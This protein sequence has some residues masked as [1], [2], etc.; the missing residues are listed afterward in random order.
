MS[1]C[2]GVQVM[3]I[4]VISGDA[5]FSEI[6]VRGLEAEFGT[7]HVVTGGSM[8][9][10][11]VNTYFYE[12]VILNSP[13][14]GGMHEREIVQRIRRKNS[15]VPILL[16]STANAGIG[17]GSD[18]HLVQP[19]TASVLRAEAKALLRRGRTAIGDTVQIA[20]LEI[21]R[22]RHEVRRSGRRVELTLK[23]YSLLEYLATRP[24]NPVSRQMIVEQ[25]WDES[26]SGLTHVVDVY[27]RHL[28]AKLDEPYAQK[29]I[30][31]VKGVGYMVSDH[32]PL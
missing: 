5:S 2:Y 16:V 1:T 6:A 3:R 11:M 19:I 25:V 15:H 24:G 10:A 28:R 30:Q 21:D 32:S 18:S 4:L 17:I 12:L 27:V 13:L 31:T 22:L 26:F 7:V 20:D 8:G 23:E 14:A 29:L 9:W